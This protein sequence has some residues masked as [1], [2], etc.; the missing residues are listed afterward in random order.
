MEAIADC[1]LKKISPHLFFF[2]VLMEATIMGWDCHEPP[3]AAKQSLRV[4]RD[5]MASAGNPG[6]Q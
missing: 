4:L 2:A 5:E 6:W 1:G 3:H